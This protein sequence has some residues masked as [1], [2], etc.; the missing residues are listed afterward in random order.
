M[1]GHFVREW[2]FPTEQHFGDPQEIWF[3]HNPDRLEAT[4][5]EPTFSF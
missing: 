1:L 3:G 4:G 2:S 5:G